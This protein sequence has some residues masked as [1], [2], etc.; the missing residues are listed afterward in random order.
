MTDSEL[1]ITTLVVV[2]GCWSFL[3][4]IGKDKH[5]RERTLEVLHR[6]ELRDARMRKLLESP[7][8]ES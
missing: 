3:R 8:E 6:R 7:P 2:V 4:V 5:H 1:L